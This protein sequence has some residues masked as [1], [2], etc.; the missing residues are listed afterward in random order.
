MTKLADGG[1]TSVP[2]VTNKV[3]SEEF[4]IGGSVFKVLAGAGDSVRT[5]AAP[6][7]TVDGTSGAFVTS[8]GTA[9]GVV[10]S[11]LFADAF[12]SSVTFNDVMDET[13]EVAVTFSPVNKTSLVALS[14]DSEL[15]LVVVASCPSMSVNFVTHISKAT[16]ITKKEITKTITRIFR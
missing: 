3:T 11:K 1:K 13:V 10:E 7:V 4:A 14:T 6:S 2:F 16:K 5:S 8:I 9:G 15:A 12:N